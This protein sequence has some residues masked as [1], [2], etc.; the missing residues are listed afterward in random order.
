MRLRS[1]LP[2]A[3]LTTVG[4]LIL[5]QA[6]SLYIRYFGTSW[7]SYGAIGAVIILLLWLNY[8]ATILMV[9]AVLNV[10]IE[11]ALHGHVNASR[12]KVHD[13]IARRRDQNE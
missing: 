4:W 5:A 1:V 13:F 2:G 7:N 12:G 11:E 3:A 10:V 6:F 9:G 8:S